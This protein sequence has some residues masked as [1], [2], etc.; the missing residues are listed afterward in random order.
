[1]VLGRGPVKR[2]AA[3][4]TVQLG[5][6]PHLFECLLVRS[7][8]ALQMPAAQLAFL[9]LHITG[10]LARL[11]FFKRYSHTAQINRIGFQLRV[12]SPCLILPALFYVSERSI[13]IFE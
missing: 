2:V 6:T 8:P 9:A 11:F 12:C 3:L 10:S 1:M 13:G 5:V 7:V 4:A